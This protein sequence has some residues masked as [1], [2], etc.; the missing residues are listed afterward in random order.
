M[1]RAFSSCTAFL[2]SYNRAPP[3]DE[4]VVQAGAI[5]LFTH[6]FSASQLSTDQHGLEE[7]PDA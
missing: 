3:L 7:I 5:N 1:A 6:A 2:D 4:V